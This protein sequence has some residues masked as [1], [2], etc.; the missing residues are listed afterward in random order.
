MWK[1][2]RPESLTDK[3]TLTAEEAAEIECAADATGQADVDIGYNAGFLHMGTKLAGTLR[4]SLAVEPPNGRPPTPTAAV[5]RRWAEWRETWSRAPRTPA[6][7]PPAT[8][9]PIGFNAGPPMLA[10]AYNNIMRVFQ[11]PGYAAILND[12]A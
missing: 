9:C 3:E 1:P 8:R 5:L 2:E 12:G 11:A 4:T 6:D 10:G 7:R